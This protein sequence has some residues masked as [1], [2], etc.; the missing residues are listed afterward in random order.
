MEREKKGFEPKFT[1]GLVLQCNLIALAELKQFLDETGINVVYQ[2]T[3]GSDKKL[4]I[5][6]K[7]RESE[8]YEKK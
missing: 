6:E 7:K 8:G 4:I 1:V 5:E 2:R 3:V